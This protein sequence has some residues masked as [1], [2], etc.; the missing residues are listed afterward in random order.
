MAYKIINGHLILE[1]NM[2]PKFQNQRPQRECNGVKV[3]SNNQ[4]FEPQ[5]RL[6]V[7]GS[8]FFYETPMLWNTLISPSQANAPSVDAFKSNLR[9]RIIS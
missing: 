4:L 7:I 5:S 3:G 2:M 8:T 9:K 6:E 1:P